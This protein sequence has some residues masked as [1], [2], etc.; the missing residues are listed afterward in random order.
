MTLSRTSLG[1][2]FAG[3]LVAGASVAAAAQPPGY[4]VEVAPEAVEETVFDWSSQ[5][6]EK[7][8]IPDAPLRA[9]RDDRNEVVAFASHHRSRA[10]TGPGLERLS[11]S[12]AVAFEG[13]HNADPSAYSDFSWI[14]ATW[15]GNGRDVF[16][17]MHDEYH[18]Q[19]HPGACRFK[20]AMRC[21]YNVVT[22]AR[23]RDGGRSFAGTQPP[24]LVA[25][26]AFRQEVGQGRHRGFFNPSNIIT[27]DGAWY[28]LIATTGG[29]GQKPGVCLFRTTEIGDPAS[30]RAFDG[31]D[32]SLR[33]IDPYREDMSQAKPCQ[34]LKELP[35]TVGSVTRHEVSGLWLAIFHLGPDP[36]KGI[37]G[38]RVAYSWS[39]DLRFWTP[40]QTLLTHPTMWSKECGDQVR[41][42]YGAIADP[43]SSSRNFETMGD[44]AFLFMTKMRVSDCKVGPQRDL[45][46]IRVRIVKE[47]P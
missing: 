16:A 25:A 2:L 12:C 43:A 11:T 6:C 5:R 24:S 42:A 19:D 47:T 29:E 38:G 35:T 32:F 15:T 33:A 28:T 46:R 27:Q 22:A 13:K 20:E 45:V 7:W 37:E 9:Y 26:P 21:W 4:R 30:W 44:E 8:H 31:A 40:L 14:G 41:Y 36:A 10:M 39:R 17:L 3:A 34:P 23:S 18:A 1:G